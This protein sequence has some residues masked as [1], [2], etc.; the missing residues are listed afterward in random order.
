MSSNE[1]LPSN[2]IRQIINN[3]LK[4]N[5]NDGKVATRFPP[6]P[7]GYLHIG[8][9]K[10]IC[11]NF[12]IAGEYQG[13]CNLRFDDTNPEKESIEY[14]EAIERDVSWLGFQWH[15][16]RHASDYFEQLYYYAVE[17]IQKGLAYVD[18]STP[19][20]MRQNRGTLTEPG[21][22]SPDRNRSIEENLDLFTRMRAGEFAD[23]QYVLRAKI[24][25]ASPNINMRDPVIY[26]IRQVHHHRTGD[27]WCVYPMYDYTHCISDAIEGITHSL[28][29]LEFEDHRPLYDWVLDNITI[30]C[31]PQQIEFARLQLEYSIVSKRKLNQLVAEK[32]V[33]GWDDP[34]MPTLAGLRRAGV[35]PAA[36]RDFCE[37]IGITKKDSW[38]EM[39]VLENCIREDLN[40]NA[41]RAMA[42]LRPLKLIIDNYPDDKTEALELGNHPQKPE[43]GTRKVEFSKILY[44]EQDDFAENP[45]PKYKR[46]VE[47]SEVRLRGAYVIRCD[48]IVKDENGSI[49]ELHCSYDPDTLGKNPEGRK[50][51]GVIHWVSERHS[52][53]A[54]IRLYDRLFSQ[55]NP[56][57][58]DNFLDALNPDSLEIL[59]ESRV[60]SS[61][62]DAPPES[63]FQFE[64]MG[65]FCLDAIDSTPGKPVFNRTVTLR[66]TWE[67]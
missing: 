11:L 9:A 62:A 44:I 67:K 2:F 41:P 51:K 60:E 6:E 25:M 29:T 42:V 4:Q 10:S 3:D 32:H 5:K 15:E 52:V 58:L 57:S 27:Q 1:T 12:G 37:R 19:E 21:K 26:R 59:T 23:G 47:G 46:L 48:R 28:C 16:L 36:I 63:R 30:P 22:E 40:E 14:M 20:Q 24:D 43:L 45:P 39:A 64:R 35:T 38:I 7:N 50:V 56:D 53:P 55:P 31:H 66:D 18:S 33:N 61:L 49:I 13:T 8:H 54:E 65:Y 17:L 34:R